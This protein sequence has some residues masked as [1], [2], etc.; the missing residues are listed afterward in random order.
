MG[1]GCG[2]NAAMLYTRIRTRRATV[3]ADRAGRCGNSRMRVRFT[4][5]ATIAK[6][7]RAAEEPA[8]A[9]KKLVHMGGVV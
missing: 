5:M 7:A 9:M 2:I 1:S 6:P 4:E 3:A 8:A